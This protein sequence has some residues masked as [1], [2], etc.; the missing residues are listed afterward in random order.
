M[1]EKIKLFAGWLWQN[2]KMA[3]GAAVISVFPLVIVREIDASVDMSN[4]TLALILGAMFVVWLFFTILAITWRDHQEEALHQWQWQNQWCIVRGPADPDPDP[5]VWPLNQAAD[6]LQ[7]IADELS[8]PECHEYGEAVTYRITMIAGHTPEQLQ[9][10]IKPEKADRQEH[11]AQNAGFEETTTLTHEQIREMKRA[12]LPTSQD[13]QKAILKNYIEN[14]IHLGKNGTT[15]A[16]YV[17]T[18]SE[19]NAMLKDAQEAAAA[20][21][22]QWDDALMSQVR[23]AFE[24]EDARQQAAKKEA[25]HEMD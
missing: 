14:M 12:Y 11:L 15:E 16:G 7:E 6:W 5:V 18:V 4:N 25:G 24:K 9:A 2:I 10:I 17:P 21:G 22:I 3:L 1:K 13:M 20:C 19:V 8:D 23:E